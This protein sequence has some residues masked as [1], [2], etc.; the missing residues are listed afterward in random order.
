[1]ARSFLFYI[2]AHITTRKRDLGF[3][4]IDRK[5]IGKQGETRGVTMEK[6]MEKTFDDLRE[7]LDYFTANI[8]HLPATYTI[9][10]VQKLLAFSD[11]LKPLYVAAIATIGDTRKEED[12]S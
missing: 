11:E 3:L 1:M 8:D 5:R 4:C 10:Y 9:A 2:L 12:Q 6:E 7:I